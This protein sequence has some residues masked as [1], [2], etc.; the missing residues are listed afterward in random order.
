MPT[1]CLAIV[2]NFDVNILDGVHAMMLSAA[3][4]ETRPR[5]IDLSW[6]VSSDPGIRL[7]SAHT[8]A[9]A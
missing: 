8:Y 1:I 2:Y 5:Y 3:T 7:R 6:N 4:V 9:F